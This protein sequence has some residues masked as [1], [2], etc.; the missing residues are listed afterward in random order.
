MGID[1]FALKKRHTYGTVLINHENNKIIDMID[2]RDIGDINNM[3][4][5]Y[6]SIELVTRDGSGIY[7]QAIEIANPNI[8]QISDR[9]HLIKGLSEAIN[10]TIRNLLPRVITLD[11]VQDDVKHKTLKE[12]FLSAKNDIESGLN[13]SKACEKNNINYQTMKKLLAF[14]KY[15]IEKY[16]EDKYIK[17]RLIRIDIKNEL[18]EKAKE[19]HKNGLSISEI[20]RKLNISRQTINKYIKNDISFTFENTKKDKYNSCE[21]YKEKI[22][23]LLLVN[24]KLNHIYKEICKDGYDRTYGSLKNYIKKLKENKEITFSLVIRRKYIIELLYKNLKDIKDVNRELIKKIYNKYDIIKKLIELM[25]EY[26]GIL[27]KTRKIKALSKWIDKAKRLNIPQINSF[28]KGMENDYDAIT[29]AI[30]YRESNG[31]VEASVNKIKKIKQVMH[32]RS[33]FNLL[34]SKTLRLEFNSYFN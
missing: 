33:S 2:S 10:I 25:K 13:L 26:K 14:N 21:P 16:F 32:G 19:F 5:K 7:K 22:M 11:D 34:K 24:S 27:L 28:I 9:F 18:V 6:P 31:V 30:V 4:R 12:K 20:S 8:I 17:E 1:D 15:E 23:T 3:L 29:N